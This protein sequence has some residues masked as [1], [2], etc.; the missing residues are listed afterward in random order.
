MATGVLNCWGSNSNG[1]IG[2]GTTI[3]RP[4][5][6]VNS[7]GANVDAAA[8]L[9]NS[10]VAQVTALINCEAG[11][12]AHI[13]LSLFQG[14]TTGRGQGEARCEGRLQRVLMNIPALGPSGFQSGTATAQVQ[15]TVASTG[16]I[17][18]DTHWTRTVVLSPTE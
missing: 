2:D 5:T 14:A 1:Q 3:N 13:I 15:A 16:G 9:R 6:T 10:R 12:Q 8:T 4:P 18:E 7:F 11:A 17:L